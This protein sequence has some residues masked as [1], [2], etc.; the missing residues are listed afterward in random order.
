MNPIHAVAQANPGF[1]LG[2]L[3]QPQPGAAI[4]RIETVRTQQ[5]GGA[6]MGYMQSASIVWFEQLYRKLSPT[7]MFGA[8]PNKPVTFTMGSFR[9][10]QSMVLVIVDYSFDVYRFSG[11]AAADYIPVESRRLSTQIGWDILVDGRHQGQLSYQ[12]IPQPQTQTQQPFANFVP[13]QP[14]EGWEFDQI[15]ALQSQVPAGPALS[16]MPQ[17]HHRDGLVKL[18]N[19]YVAM[20]GSTLLV[21]CSILNQIPIP[22]AFFE[23]DITG[24]LMPQT[25]YDAY[26]QIAVA[27]GNP[28][29]PPVP[30]AP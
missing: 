21:N 10:P 15:R 22:I 19:S 7:G 6:L 26:Q 23:A 3:P 12:I 29:V 9:V 17:R 18:A 11:A 14:A 20:S 28:V 5:P 13:G 8:T 1:K 30:G 2:A 25:A 16:M 24:M 4:T 27:M